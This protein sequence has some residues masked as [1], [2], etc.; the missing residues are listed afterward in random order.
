MPRLRHAWGASL[1]SRKSWPTLNTSSAGRGTSRKTGEFRGGQDRGIWFYRQLFNYLQFYAL[2][3]YED[4]EGEDTFDL[5]AV[6]I[7]TVHQAKGLEWPV[8][9]LPALVDGRFPS[10]SRKAAGLA[11]SSITVSAQ[12]PAAA[13]KAAK[14][15]NGDFSTSPSHG[16]RMSFTCL[17]SARRRTDSSRRHSCSKW[18]AA[19]LT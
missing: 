17:A 18:R 16:P 6:D 19:I 9:F 14:R 2:D 11:D 8:V 5:D 15:K 12:R 13:T 3:A 7:L 1:G 4:F 10:K